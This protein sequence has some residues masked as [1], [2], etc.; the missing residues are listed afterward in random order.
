MSKGDDVVAGIVALCVLLC[1]LASFPASLLATFYLAAPLALTLG[2]DVADDGRALLLIFGG[3][4]YVLLGLI[5]WAGFA[6]AHTGD[7]RHP[8][9]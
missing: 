7:T 2:L 9:R 3:I 5:L 4:E 8:R 6:W 1:I